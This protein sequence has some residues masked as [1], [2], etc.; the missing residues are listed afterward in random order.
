MTVFSWRHAGDVLEKARKMCWLRVAQFEGDIL[1]FNIGQA[2][3]LAG[4]FKPDFQNEV[5]VT[6]S[7]IRQVPL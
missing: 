6:A 5:P 2:K 1:H 7:R 3:K 4:A